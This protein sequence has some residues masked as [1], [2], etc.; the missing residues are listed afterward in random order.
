MTTERPKEV[1]PYGFLLVI[2]MTIE[3]FTDYEFNQNT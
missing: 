1:R 3:K 2:W